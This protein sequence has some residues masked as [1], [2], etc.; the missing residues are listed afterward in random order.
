MVFIRYFISCFDE[1]SII[2]GCGHYH[3]LS[4]GSIFVV[5]IHGFNSGSR[6]YLEKESTAIGGWIGVLVANRVHWSSRGHDFV[7]HQPYNS[8][9]SKGSE[10]LSFILELYTSGTHTFTQANTHTHTHTHVHTH[11]I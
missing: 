5:C 8:M 9:G 7:S 10:T 6:K 4:Q 3:I 2:V 1:V 11:A